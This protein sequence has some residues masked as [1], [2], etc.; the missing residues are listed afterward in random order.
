ME[1]TPSSATPR[2]TKGR[3]AKPAVPKSSASATKPEGKPETKPAAKPKVAAAPGKRKAVTS[4]R[5]PAPA[6]ADLTPMI[7]TAAYFLAER[8]QFA[9]GHEMQDWLVAEQQIRDGMQ[10]K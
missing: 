8:R 4:P 7:A 9:P 10:A 1:I 2:T 3:A 6:T 5:E